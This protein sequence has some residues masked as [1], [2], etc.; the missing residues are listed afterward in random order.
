MSELPQGIEN[1]FTVAFDHQLGLLE[2]Q[3]TVTD[4]TV[5]ASEVFMIENKIYTTLNS[6][7]TTSQWVLTLLH[8]WG[9]RE[10]IL[11]ETTLRILSPTRKQKV[12]FVFQRL[13]SICSYCTCA[14]LLSSSDSSLPFSPDFISTT[15]SLFTSPP[16][17]HGRHTAHYSK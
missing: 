4:S 1:V 2:I 9:G 6:E 11:K 8:R 10:G 12:F 15:M 3:Y 13:T 5:E 16:A 7:K 14:D 17:L